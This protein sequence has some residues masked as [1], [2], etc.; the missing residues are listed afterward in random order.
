MLF[1][2]LLVRSG[3]GVIERSG[4]PTERLGVPTFGGGAASSAIVEFEGVSLS[5][6]RRKSVSI[7][8][9][10]SSFTKIGTEA[11]TSKMGG[12]QLCRIR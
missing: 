9:E 8:A 7:S 3:S 2:S 10:K 5:R 6:S 11:V 1:M 12:W 4:V